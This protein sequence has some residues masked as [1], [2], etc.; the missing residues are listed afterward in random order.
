[1]IHYHGL[2]VTPATAAAR[3]LAGRH[4]F[5]SFAH[6]EQLDIATELCQSFA[7]DNGAF[8]AWKSGKAITDWSPFY[9]W[10]GSLKS[11]P[12]FDFAVIPDVID[13]DEIANDDLIREWPHEKHFSAPV[14]HMHES[15][16]RLFDLAHFWPRVCIGSSGAYAQIG[17]PQWWTRISEALNSICDEHGRPATRLHG[18]RM[19]D[20]ALFTKLPFASADSTNIGRNIGIDS[21]WRG[22]YQPPTKE[23]RAE[24][25]AARIE[26]HNSAQQWQRVAVQES[27][28]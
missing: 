27:F 5:V 15:I 19:L 7:V 6:P 26:S 22:T 8:T 20:P 18:L 21:A 23:W 28:L 12:G 3:L 13:G 2:P 9:E 16:E 24:L 25:M 10:V 1:M 17:T 11:H 4:A 14:W